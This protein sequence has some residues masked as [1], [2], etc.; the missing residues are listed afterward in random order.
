MNLNG[1]VAGCH[2]YEYQVVVPGEDERRAKMAEAED[3][4]RDMRLRS[5]ASCL[6]M[7][8]LHH[9]KPRLH[10]TLHTLSQTYGH[11]F[12]L[13]FGSRLVVVVSCPT[14]AQQCLTKYDSV[15]ANRPRLLT[16]KYLFY[17]N[18]SL[19]VSSNSDHWRNLRRIATTDVLSTPRLN[20][21][22]ETRRDEGAI[23]AQDDGDVT[24]QY[25]EDGL[26]RKEE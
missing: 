19:V 18:T 25:H 2:A 20:S 24:Q 22:L 17:N 6:G 7:G 4:E 21:F 13:W 14:L 23:E 9:L 11:I 3:G 8:N 5:K 1:S 15:L 12:S 16:G 10:R 26:R